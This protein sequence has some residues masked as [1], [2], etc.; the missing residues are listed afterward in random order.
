MDRPSHPVGPLLQR[1][2][3]TRAKRIARPPL[4]SINKRRA[5]SRLA[6]LLRGPE[7]PNGYKVEIGAG[8]HR[9]EGWLATD[10]TWNCPFWLDATEPW[11]FPAGS[12][13][14][15]Y[16]DNVIEHISLRENREL[17]RHARAVMGPGGTIRLCT[18][19]I[20]RLVSLYCAANADTRETLAWSQSQGHV[21]VHAVDLLRI[22]FT[23]HGHHLGY[24]WDIESL[25]AELLTAGFVNPRRCD[26]GES[27]D[28]VLR[29]LEARDSHVE[30]AIQLTVEADVA[31][32]AH[33]HS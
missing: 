7:P 27:S 21:A 14:Y 1:Q 12:V 19:D 3:W 26:A 16:A 17:F 24:M 11:P 23:E 25:S 29:G 22:A 10:V 5:Q 2:F 8:P 4:T 30:A 28:P 33:S 9:K 32:D 13:R 15:V 18:P 20:G 6:E 31:L